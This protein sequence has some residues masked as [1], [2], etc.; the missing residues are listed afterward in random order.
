MNEKIR[1]Q[2]LAIRDTGLTNMFDK[3]AVQRLAIERE[4]FELVGFIEENTKAYVRFILTGE[5]E[6][7][8]SAAFARKAFN[9]DDLIEWDKAAKQRSRFII[10]KNIVLSASEYKEF[11]D[12]LLS[13]R[14]FVEENVKRMYTDKNKTQHCILVKEEGRSEGILIQSE[15]Y[16]YPRYTVYYKE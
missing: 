9:L 10:E 12:N 4:Y 2:I 6:E 13:D 14:G 5:S 11:C 16:S 15:G 3:L 8:E 7:Q 1:N